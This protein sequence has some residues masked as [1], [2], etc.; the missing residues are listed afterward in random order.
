MQRNWLKRKSELLSSLPIK[1]AVQALGNAFSQ[2][3]EC[4][5][6]GGNIYSCVKLPQHMLAACN[7]C[8]AGFAGLLQ[9]SAQR[10]QAFSEDPKSQ[11]AHCVCRGGQLLGRLNLVAPRA[12]DM[13]PALVAEWRLRAAR[14]QGFR[15][16]KGPKRDQG[17]GS[18]L[19]RLSPA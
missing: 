1:Q 4:C 13:E 11:L 16:H 12:D 6:R 9:C 17:S 10:H 2:T 14:V 15:M 18:D 5:H 3:D 19:T 7:F 8:A